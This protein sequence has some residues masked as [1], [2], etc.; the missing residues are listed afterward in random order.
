MGLLKLLFS[1]K[2]RINRSQYW[3]GSLGVGFGSVFLIIF[4]M[5]VAGPSGAGDKGQAMMHAITAFS[6]IVFPVSL[7]AGWAGMALQVKRFHDRGR[8]GLFAMAPMLPIAMIFMSFVGGA[9]SGQ[10]AGQVARAIG[11][12][13]MLL[14][15]IQFA[16][17]IDLG[18]LP[19]KDGPNKYGDPPGSA[20]PSAPRAPSASAPPVTAPLFGAQS[21][22]DRA[23]AEEARKQQQPPVEQPRPAPQRAYATAATGGATPSFGRRAAR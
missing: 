21:A 7:V 20:A 9:M 12:W 11:G 14:W 10:D 1:F 17:F 22:M 6:L 2:G 18:C 19:G 15:A 3:L 8:S 5:L 4:L 16:L 23:I 13:M